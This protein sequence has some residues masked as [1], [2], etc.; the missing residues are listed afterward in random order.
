MNDQ[1]K[2]KQTLIKELD[3]LRQRI[4]ELEQSESE[5]NHVKEALRKGKVDLRYLEQAPLAYQ[6]LDE[7]GNFLQVNQTW[8]N[9][10]GYK[11][12]E[13]LGKNFSDFLHPNWV[14]HFRENFPRFKDTGEIRGVEFEMV[15]K[16][17]STILVSF[18]GKIGRDNQGR[19][20]QTHCIFQDITERKQIDEL[21]RKSEEKY[22]TLFEESFDGL[23][24]TSPMGRIL[25]MNKKGVMMFGYDTKE[26]ILSLDL[27]RD[28]YAHPPDRKRILSLV[29]TQGAAEYEVVV[30]RKNGE[31]M[32]THCSLA[33]VKDESGVITSYRGI[34]R[35]ISEHRQVEEALRE[36]EEL[37]R[38]TITNIMDPVFITD[39]DG[40]FTFICPNIPYILGYST[41]EIQ[42]MGNIAALLSDPKSLFDIEDLNRQETITNV[43]AVIAQKD[44]TKRDYLV[45]VKGVSI[46]GGTILYV[47]RDVTERKQAEEKL[48]RVNRALRMLSDTNQALIHIT[49]EATLLNEVCRIAVDV[50]GYRLV[51]VG[52]AEQD[53]AKTV[54][55]VAH[56]G[57]ESGY[58]E[59]V[60]V[61]WADNERGR[62]P[63]G[64]AI[65]T[66]QPCISR[67]I[68]GDPAFAPWREAA[69]QRGYKSIIALP[70]ITEGQT[71][72]A[73][74]IYADKVD[75]F[76]D[77]EVE[78]LKELAGDL[79]F[80]ITALR[81]RIKRDQ[82]EVALHESEKRVRRKLDAILS[83]EADIGALE[84]SD[85]I[86]SE[87][88]QKLMNEFYGLTRIGI[89][90]IDLKGRVLVG[91]GW[92]DI[93]TKF[94]RINPKSC[95]LCIE[96][97]LELSRNV[98][99]DTFKLYR[100]KNNMWDMAT[101]I[102]LGD[103]HVGNIFLGQFL[104]DDE[105]PDYETFRQQ[106]R[107]YGFDEQEYLA[108]LDRVPRWSRQTVNAAMSFYSVFA[109]M[110][111]RLSYGNIKLLYALEER[112]W[113]EE[114]IQASLRE[115]ETMLKEI[116]H[117]VKN[118]MQ[119]ISSLLGLQSSYVQDEQSRKIFQESQDRVKTM[120]MI[121]TQ[122]YQ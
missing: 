10:L 102:I 67:S 114:K 65:R 50:G 43:E 70:L 60:K 121:H 120:A 80:G 28:V 64:T 101:P 46:K 2:T 76:D 87:M 104:F 62:G 119:V 20:E 117:R 90:I 48:S 47:C 41:E 77:R 82:T 122:L 13:V 74:G 31:T 25:D 29:N 96:S 17:G 26:E 19:F 100:C 16:D 1:S 54:R 45:T 12:E 68:P 56:A 91:T 11:R 69:I 18:N 63:G 36:S 8:L 85:I 94:H 110:I 33:A 113:A 59:S 106:A 88:L 15:K 30:K 118:N 93:C 40:K 9:T 35:D 72:G 108:A 58:I 97:D 49:D 22:R 109:G 5:R 23:F 84:L 44:G 51:W 3:S 79:A 55:P 95:R 27:E 115:K 83:P 112:K 98:P 61:T 78:I 92:Q 57:F 71:L 38:I 73:L 37:H 105:T 14:D 7:N 53:E 39:S 107:R 32:I 6:S 24:I 34:I 99:A 52:F 116:H 4:A 21:L 42:A 75:A 103:K 86:D 81:A 89:G 111:G 66:G